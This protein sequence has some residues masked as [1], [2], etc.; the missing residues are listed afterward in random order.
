M[1][2]SQLQIP[3]VIVLATL[4]CTTLEGQILPDG[5]TVEL[6][7]TG[8][9]FTEGPVYDGEGSLYFTNIYF[10]ATPSQ[11]IRYD[12][13]TRTTEVAVADLGMAN[14]LFFDQEGQLISMDMG[15]GQVS[16]RAANGI[17]LLSRNWEGGSMDGLL[18]AP[19]V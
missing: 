18:T 9:N 12:E 1:R 19:T 14:G 7:A 8:F 6:L 16:R 3:F 11:I 2:T 17:N 5:A 4:S 15:A 10:S 13:S